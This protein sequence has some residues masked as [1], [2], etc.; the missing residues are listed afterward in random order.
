MSEPLYLHYSLVVVS[1]SLVV[2]SHSLVVVSDTRETGG[3]PLVG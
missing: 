3:V 1:H 2:V